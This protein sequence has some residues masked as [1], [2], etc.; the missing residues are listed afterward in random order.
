MAAESPATETLVIFNPSMFKRAGTVAVDPM[1][2]VTS[3]LKLYGKSIFVGYGKGPLAA[4]EALNAPYIPSK[5]HECAVHSYKEFVVLQV[6]HARV[7]NGRSVEKATEEANAFGAQI[8]SLHI[9]SAIPVVVTREYTIKATNSQRNI[10]PAIMITRTFVELNLPTHVASNISGE[11]VQIKTSDILRVHWKYC[12]TALRIGYG[13]RG[14]ASSDDVLSLQSYHFHDALLDWIEDPTRVDM[15]C[16]TRPAID[17]DRV[18]ARADEWTSEGVK[19]SRS[20]ASQRAWLV[21]QQHLPEK[22]ILAP[23]RAT[24]DPCSP[25]PAKRP[26]L[27][28]EKESLPSKYGK[29]LVCMDGE[30]NMVYLHCCHLAVCEACIEKSADLKRTCPYCREHSN[31]V[32]KIYNVGCADDRKPENK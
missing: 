15:H 18:A 14:H 5:S 30:A 16:V 3:M 13:V 10:K 4:F 28:E 25:P 17:Y 2:I 22:E 31:S 19:V 9:R 29:C 20:A 32:M 12:N 11:V 1:P 8:R 24:S 27:E 21:S 6:P 7:W 23:V 26:K